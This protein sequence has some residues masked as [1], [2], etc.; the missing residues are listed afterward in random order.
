MCTLGWYPHATH[1]SSM[2]GHVVSI[3][4]L[5]I[6]FG[7]H[8]NAAYG[9][10]IWYI[11]PCPPILAPQLLD[12]CAAVLKLKSKSTLS[13]CSNVGHRLDS[14]A[15]CCGFWLT[16]RFIIL[17]CDLAVCS[18]SFA[19]SFLFECPQNGKLIMGER[20]VGCR[21]KWNRFMSAAIKGVGDQ[22]YWVYQKTSHLYW[23]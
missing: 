17:I 11:H 5:Q 4:I 10:Y 19:H 20:W 1:T 6:T 2:G 12:K 15:I 18:T 9:P 16:F 7:S 13:H 14:P 3:P 21:S 22:E 23:Y 8:W